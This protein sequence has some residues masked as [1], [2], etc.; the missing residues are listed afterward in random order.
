MQLHGD[1]VETVLVSFCALLSCTF[2][3]YK[4]YI[5]Q[6]NGFPTTHGITVI[7]FALHMVLQF[8][9]IDFV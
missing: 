9:V 2:S 4:Y 6:G 3:H 7:D 8:S 5:S 1:S